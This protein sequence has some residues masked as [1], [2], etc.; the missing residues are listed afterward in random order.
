MSIIGLRI[1]ASLPRW[2]LRSVDHDHA[3]SSKDVPMG[4]QPGGAEARID[5][6]QD[7]WIGANVVVLNGVRISRGAIVAAGS[8]LTRSVGA[9]EIWGGVPARK[10]RERPL[11]SP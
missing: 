6:E 9:Y 5:I 8:V 11:A 7:V 1:S 3:F 10:L 4:K 2:G